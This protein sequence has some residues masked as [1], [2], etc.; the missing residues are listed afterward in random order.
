MNYSDVARAYK[1]NGL[2]VVPLQTDGSKS[3]VGS[4][5]PYQSRFASDHEISQW[6]DGEHPCGIGVVAGAV[7]GNL[8]VIDF[9]HEAEL[10]FEKVWE[11]TTQRLPDVHSQLVVIA[12]PRPGRQVWFRQTSQPG[13]N[14]VLAY[15]ARDTND[16]HPILIE[17]RGEG[18]YV[19]APGSP[20]EVHST[21]IAYQKLHGEF[22]SLEP[23]SDE[24]S[25][26]LLD[27]CRSY[28]QYTP[29]ARETSCEPY[30][31]E[32]RPGDIY[33][34]KVDLWDML[35]KH[36]WQLHHDAPDGRYV[37]RP[38]KSV[39]D[40]YSASL[41]H[42][43]GDNGQPLLRVF[44][45]AAAPFEANTSYDAFG[46]Y[47][48][49]EHNG[50]FGM[51]ASAVRQMFTTDVA[52]AQ[53][54]FHQ[55]ES[56]QIRSRT[57]DG[58]A[59]TEINWLW[60]QRIALGKLTLLAGEPGLGKT[61]LACDIAARISKGRL[62]PDGTMA[63]IGDVAILTAEDSAA[64]TLRPRLDAAGANVELV[65]HIDGC[66]ND[67]GREEMIS[68]DRH[69]Q[70]LDE[71]LVAHPALRLFIV[72]P[73]SAFLGRI[74]SHKNAEVRA[75][76]GPVADLAEKHRIAVLAITH[77]SKQQSRAI[78]RITGSIAFVAAARAAWLVTSDP[79]DE[80]RRLLLPVKNNLSSMD[81][82]AFR[83]VDGHLAW[84]DAAVTLGVD[85]V[86][87][88]S[89]TPR[90]E[91]MTWIQSRL[92]NGPIP[93][94]EIL[95]SARTEGVCV[96]TLKRAKKELNVLSKRIGDQWIWQWPDENT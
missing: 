34:S 68:L 96:R 7:S 13:P 76:L 20:P 19:V 52:T 74:D 42:V 24:Q 94:A 61:F 92:Q 46:V 40:G 80:G 64:D 27:I 93:A 67:A 16:S 10:Y 51:A 95:E 17:T 69:L 3:P 31:G 56:L 32:P 77:L 59:A 33:N 84:E 4:W 43:C 75:I 48:L 35:S 85:D 12:T 28:S 8:V 21:G 70:A 54:T 83:I 57:Y 25:T 2:S 1:S 86:D 22:E 41:G 18:G 50:D 90:E 38:G 73:I 47:A 91:A 62:F 30:E 6:F 81:G 88:A 39:H 23:I 45:S 55:Q 65:H 60:E 89:D 87:T 71:W 36:G 37:T 63:S 29:P 44:S 53:Q 26:I 58:I 9:D 5:K 66:R 15:G 11:E 79:D 78:N 72:D 49:L 82:L 14:T